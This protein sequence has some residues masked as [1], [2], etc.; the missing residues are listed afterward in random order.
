MQPRF[1]VIVLGAGVAGLSAASLLADRFPRIQ[2]LDSFEQLGGTQRSI[3][4]NGYTFDIGSY[5]F[6]PNTVLFQRHPGLM[7]STVAA[8]CRSERIRPDGSIAGYPFAPHELREPGVAKKGAFVLSFMA[9]RVAPRA[10][11]NIEQV[12]HRMI[13][14]A[15]YEH[16][17]LSNY[18]ARFYGDDLPP[19]RID[20]VFADKRLQFLRKRT[21]IAPALKT[22]RDVYFPGRGMDAG[23]PP[24]SPQDHVGRVRAEAGFPAMYE[25]V[26]A[27]LKRLGVHIELGRSLQRIE[28]TGEGFRVTTGEGQ[29]TAG[30][31]VSTLPVQ[32]LLGLLGHPAGPALR[33]GALLTLCVSFAGERGFDGGVLFNFNGRGQWKRLTM[34]SDFY[35]RR[36]GRE[37]FSVEISVPDERVLSPVQA[38]AD[39]DQSVRAHGLFAGD[40]R[41]EASAFTPF[42]Y[43]RYELGYEKAL[44]DA[45]AVI[46]ASGVI[47]AG[48]QGRFDYLPTSGLIGRQV[49]ESLQLLVA[50]A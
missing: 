44:S 23:Q 22:M 15:F 17:G 39:F 43:P 4:A 2:L 47:V 20:P 26:G 36:G 12:C 48:R 42:A 38:F 25:P 34:H 45:M 11:R 13:G 37:Y 49:R 16:S 28:R 8:P 14:K 1:D 6:Y 3:E 33:S 24:P 29:V 5:F 7:E 21:R 30:H 41:L 27:D 50:P 40:L 31:V 32:V 35:G 10:D 19:S 18:V 9:G 46:D